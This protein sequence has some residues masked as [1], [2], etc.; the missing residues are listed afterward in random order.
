MSAVDYRVDPVRAG[1]FYEAIRRYWPGLPD[2]A[3]QPAFAGIRPKLAGPGAD[4]ADFCLQGPAEHGL[5]G[6]IALYGI[7]SPGLTAALALGRVVCARITAD[8][9]AG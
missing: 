3:L 8:A 2:G 1:R 5:P 9:R 4:G 7:E 6:L